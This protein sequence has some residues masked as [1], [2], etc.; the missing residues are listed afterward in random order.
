[1]GSTTWHAGIVA[2]LLKFCFCNVFVNGILFGV[3]TLSH[4]VV[5]VNVNYLPCIEQSCQDLTLFLVNNNI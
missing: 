1:M 4:S 5:P 3:K 2:Q